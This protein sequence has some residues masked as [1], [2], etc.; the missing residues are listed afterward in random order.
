MILTVLGTPA[1]KGSSR[2][3]I[4]GGRAVNVP[5]SSDVGRRKMVSWATAVR[6]VAAELAGDRLVPVFVDVV[7]DVAIVF[8]M[9]RPKGHWGKGRRT[10][11]I[12]PSAPPAPMTKPDI[13]KLVRATLDAMTGVIFDDDS[14]IASLSCVKQWAAP[15]TEGATIGVRAFVAIPT[16]LASSMTRSTG[17]AP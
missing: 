17:H 6:E 12:L 2:A 4:R 10:G 16:V 7:L 11:T 1:P 3:M 9:A 5:G 8:R 15:G 13:D 14:R